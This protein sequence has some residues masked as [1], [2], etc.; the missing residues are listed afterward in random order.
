MAHRIAVLIFPGFQLLDASGPTAV[1][2]AAGRYRCDAYRVRAVAR[3]AGLVRSSSGLTLQAEACDAVS[4]PDTLLVA[5]GEGVAAACRCPQTLA[6]IQ[7]CEAAGCRVASVCTG[8]FLLAEAGLLAGRRATTHWAHA[9]D[10]ARLYPDTMLETDRL[11]I[12]EGQIWTAAGVTAGIDLALALVAD[13]LGAEVARQSAQRLVVYCQ[14]PGGQSQFSS[15][16]EMQQPGG[17]FAGL[18]DHVRRNLGS[19]WTVAELAER[20]CLS[21]RHFSRL[22]LEEVGVPPAKAVERLRVEAAR[23]ALESGEASLQRLARQCGFGEVE[24]MRR[25]FLRILGAP[26]SALKR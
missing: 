15:L 19:A 22:F 1:F 16:L 6:W 18:L 25:S 14:R 17:R 24:R 9:A 5:G 23:G 26:P 21:P 20:S 12:R 4:L 10:F 8:A 7:R 11:F 3:Q 13:D 2:E